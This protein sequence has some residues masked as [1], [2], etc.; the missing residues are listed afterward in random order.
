MLISPI[1]AIVGMMAMSLSLVTAV[2][3]DGVEL[4]TCGGDFELTYF[5]F[6]IDID[7]FA[8]DEQCEDFDMVGP[9]IQKVIEQIQDSIPEYEDEF[10][11]AEVCPDP[12]EEDE[13]R[14]LRNLKNKSNNRGGNGRRMGQYKFAGTGGCRRCRRASRGQKP[15][16]LEEENETHYSIYSIQLVSFSGR[17]LKKKDVEDFDGTFADHLC[18][19]GDS[20]AVDVAIAERAVEKAQERLKELLD[21]SKDKE[22][23]DLVEGKEIDKYIEDAER[24]VKECKSDRQWAK[25]RAY[26]I[27]NA[28]S[29]VFTVD[30]ESEEDEQGYVMIADELQS[31]A[32][33]DAK[34]AQGEYYKVKDEMIGLK[35]AVIESKFEKL[36][37]EIEEEQEQLK[38][39]IEQEGKE[40]KDELKLIDGQIKAANQIQDLAEAEELKK[41]KARMQ[42]EVEKHK[43][44]FEELK[45]LKENELRSDY[46]FA[47]G[48]LEVEAA[49][50]FKDYMEAFA[51][52]VGPAL[53]DILYFELGDCFEDEPKVDVHVVELESEDEQLKKCP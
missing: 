49:N 1:L 4:K 2:D 20:V 48:K 25:A 35:T 51:G 39:E 23:K 6:D 15:R 17:K 5:N 45:Q 16:H 24:K 28:C 41:L 33:S 44:E 14:L 37:S 21:M 43:A 13:R 40:V 32:E 8:E 11:R 29:S 38:K 52:L 26:Y 30:I 10:I 27:A 3:D 22:T 7:G 46:E 42:H 53:E 31:R 47:I 18:S 36:K 9:M 12:V 34:H 50:T 19:M